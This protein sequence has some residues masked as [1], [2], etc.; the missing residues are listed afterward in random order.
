MRTYSYRANGSLDRDQS[1][2][3]KYHVVADEDHGDIGIG[4]R[5]VCRRRWGPGHLLSRRFPV[6]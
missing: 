6:R 3:Q 4:H 1:F 5:P 2:I